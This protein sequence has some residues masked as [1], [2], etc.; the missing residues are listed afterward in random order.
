MDDILDDSSRQHLKGT[1]AS[2]MWPMWMPGKDGFFI[3]CHFN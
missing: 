1:Q 3:I 2:D